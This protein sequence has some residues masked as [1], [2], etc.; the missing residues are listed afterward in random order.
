MTPLRRLFGSDKPLVGMVHLLPLPGSPRWGGS[1]AAVVRRATADARALAAGGFDAL[2]VE[3]FGDAPFLKSDLPAETVAALTR[4]VTEVA[5]ATDLPA[6]VNA[7]RNDARAALGIAAATGARFIRVNVHTGAA[8]TDQGVIE[9]RAGET[10]RHRAAW[11]G[12]VGILADLGVKHSAPLAARPL[13]EEAADAVH[14]GMADV[15]VITGPATGAF[16]RLRDFGLA[17]RA[18][19]PVLAGS[20]VTEGTVRKVL[21]V[22]DGAIVGTSIKEGGVAEGPVDPERAKRFVA[23]ARG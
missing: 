13:A 17:A 8:V 23:R 19:A 3:N 9:G 7:L 12:E 14:R 22:A 5:R 4:C 20:G 2:I 11:G 16:P 18:G 21:Q 1:M 10:L 6:G 15:L